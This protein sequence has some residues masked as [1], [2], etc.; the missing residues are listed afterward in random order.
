MLSHDG[1]RIGSCYHIQ[2]DDFMIISPYHSTWLSRLSTVLLLN[3]A[4]SH[5]P[6]FHHQTS[7]IISSTWQPRAHPHRARTMFSYSGGNA[8]NL[9]TPSMCNCRIIVLFEIPT[10]SKRSTTLSLMHRAAAMD[11]IFPNVMSCEF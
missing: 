1:Y 10:C 9:S 3:V 5:K 11:T 8:S 6:N 4:S 2:C 7:S